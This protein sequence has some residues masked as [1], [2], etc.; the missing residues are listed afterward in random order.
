MVKAI[1]AESRSLASAHHAAV[2]GFDLT[3]LDKVFA[4][5]GKLL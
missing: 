5:L 1:Q 3:T 4:G 2:R